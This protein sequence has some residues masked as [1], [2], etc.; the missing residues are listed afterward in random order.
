MATRLSR[1]LS[2]TAR[3]LSRLLMASALLCLASCGGGSGGG[4]GFLNEDPTGSLLSYTIALSIVDEAGNPVTQVSETFPARLLITVREDNFDAMPVGGL[5]VQASSEFAVIE[6]Q[7]LQALTNSDG[8]A[9]MQIIS[10]TQLGADTITVTAESPAGAVTATIGVQIVIASQTL[11]SFDGTTFVPGQIGLSTDSIPFRGSAVLRIAVVDETGATATA[12][13]TIRVSSACSLSGLSTFR[14]IGDASNGTA[15]LNVTTVDGLAELEYLAGNC[16]TSDQI[17]AALV[18]GDSVATATISIAETDAS[19]IG[20]VNSLPNESEEGN[21]RTI[22]AL[23]GTGGPGRPETATVI[24]EVLEEDFELLDTDPGPGQPGYLD[25]PQRQ[26]VAGVTVEFSLTDAQ[27]GVAIT[28]PSAVTDANGLAETTVTAGVIALSTRVIARIVDADA[29]D[30]APSA[31]S[32]EIVVGTGLP[33]QNSVSLSASVFNAPLAGNQDGV[34]VEITV[35]MADK[36]NNPVADGTPAIFTTEYGRIDA[37]CLIGRSNGGVFQQVNGNATPARGTCSVMWQS[38]A[39]RLPLFNADSVQ[40]IEDDGDY[41]CSIHNSISGGPCPSDL[42][43]IRGYRS[44]ILV[45]AVGDESFIDENGNGLYD[46]GEDFENLPEAFLDVNED[47]V[48]TPFFGPQCPPPSTNANCAAGGSEE[49]FVDRNEDGVYSVNLDP[50]IGGEVYNGSLCPVS[51][52]GIFC[53]REQVNVRA[54]QVITMSITAGQ[55]SVLAAEGS[56]GL[57][58]IVSSFREGDALEIYLSDIFNNPPGAGTVVTLSASGDCA[59][60]TPAPG[61]SL[62]LTVPNIPD[63]GAYLASF[64]INGTNAPGG[65]A[66]TISATDPGD[67]GGSFFLRTYSCSPTFCDDLEDPNDPNSECNESL[68]PSGG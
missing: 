51:G 10:G 37:S 62:E 46:Q 1:G 32:N 2:S 64:Q 31:T 38:Q 56:G 14:A 41:S 63:P 24:F 36:F 13:Q 44:T 40:T 8:V 43:A 28:I 20:F 12:A 45:T 9:E 52:D 47:G 54:S 55:Q 58:R 65:G 39:P 6:P 25:L 19:F 57:R 7:N 26:P 30:A 34:N 4:G 35:R 67:G 66:I 16:E 5:V 29:G 48:Y 23:Q 49:T 33:D 21:G 59:I 60:S 61:T 15:T 17:T 50:N 3:R 42:G 22:I 68:V 11:G 53:S 18:V 27:G